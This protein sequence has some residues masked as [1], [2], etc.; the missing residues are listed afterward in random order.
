MAERPLVYFVDDERSTLDALERLFRHELLIQSFEDPLLALKAVEKE[1]PSLILV[2]HRMPKISGLDLLQKL[3]KLSPTTVRAMLTAHV[4]LDSISEAINQGFL[5]RF[6]LK[7]WEN[8]VLKSQIRECLS[9]HQLL[10]ENVKLERLSSTDAVTGVHNH[11]YF[12][13]TL[14]VE[15][16]R[17]KRHDRVLS[18]V[19]IDLD[20]FKQ[21]NDQLGHLE[22]DRILRIVAQ[23][24]QANL[25]EIDWV[26]RYGG[27]EFSIILPDT[28]IEDAYMIAERVRKSCNIVM[29]KNLEL[30]ISLGIAVFPSHG[31]TPN[32]VLDAADKALFAAK[33]HGRNQTVIA[34]GSMT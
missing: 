16:E 9:L 12:Q 13:E 19:M 4:D 17:A 5:H 1:K 15:V 33:K 11:R 10:L 34:P 18:L 2:D 6:F 28:K 25:R 26:A 23:K 24:I 3:Q 22:G 14:R 31:I 30:S 20:N 8:D 21:A 29:S 27:D 7:P 32:E